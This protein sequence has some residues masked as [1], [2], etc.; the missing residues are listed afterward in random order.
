MSIYPLQ[1]KAQ[2]PSLMCCIPNL[3][4]P[5]LEK[6]SLKAV[7]E[8]LLAQVEVRQVFFNRG[9]EPIEAVYTFPVPRGAVL[10][11]FTARLGKRD[12][13]GRIMAAPEAEDGY[14]EAVTSGDAAILL[15]ESSPGLYTVN[16]GNLLPG[17]DA[18][19]T[20]R[21]S[22]L[23]YWQSGALRFALPTVI[24][25]RYGDPAQAGLEEHQVPEHDFFTVRHAE[26]RASIRGALQDAEITCPT[27]GIVVE[28]HAD[29]AVVRFEDSPTCTMDRDIVLNLKRAAA[30]PAVAVVEPTAAGGEC[31]GLLTFCPD[32]GRPTSA[33]PRFVK[34]LVD[35]SG[36]MQGDSIAQARVALRRIL[37]SLRPQDR[38]TI[39]AFGST[40]RFVTAECVACTPAA[41]SAARDAVKTIDADLGGT[42]LRSAL[43]ALMNVRAPG[44]E[45]ANV[46]GDV[47]LITDGETFDDDLVKKAAKA[48]GRV[49]TVGVGCAPGESLLGRLSEKTGGAAEYVTPT[50]DM[51]A[52]I[53]RHFQRLYQPRV[54]GLKI[55]WP[56]RVVQELRDRQ[57]GLFAGDTVHVL[58]RLQDAAAGEVGI[59]CELEDG[60][61]V[62]TSVALRRLVDPAGALPEAG[63]LERLMA[64]SELAT[65]R[66]SEPTAADVKR[67][68]ALAVRC[69]LMS[70]WT[71]C[72]MVALRDWNEKTD[73]MPAL[74]KV[75]QMLAAGW[76]G[77]G[78]H[79]Q[80][81]YSMAM[82]LAMR[83]CTEVLRCRIE[84]AMPEDFYVS[85]A[86]VTMPSW[87]LDKLAFMG[88]QVSVLDVLRVLVDGGADEET[89]CLLAMHELLR[90]K[91]KL[92]LDRGRSRDIR[93]DAK[94]AAK[95]SPDLARQVAAAVASALGANP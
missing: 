79:M 7:L 58:A 18:E 81:R 28:R 71:S 95:A 87:S 35:C 94:A 64:A 76:Q 84:S 33:E 57:G 43:L 11:S 86:S 65:A 44:H 1:D 5:V 56:G 61:S 38:F 22:Q 34:I 83:N 78:M 41:I 36:S 59:R 37:D 23:Q 54:T 49:F 66:D 63:F 24:A 32:P 60:S 70:K 47:L 51:A 9:H 27:H 13:T 75:Q 55:Q 77:N 30:T 73:G 21:Y 69:Q 31:V 93:R 85:R 26:F 89:V 12:L 15:Q 16:V 67:L 4:M 40:H 72:L 52:R 68:T 3:P 2:A 6:V 82:P 50:D 10:L 74:T 46:H 48:G 90:G 62:N 39:M 14:E 45:F 20:Y 53:H 92:P 42:E 88:V 17:E 80:V 91:V 8:D 19:L 25:P 29:H